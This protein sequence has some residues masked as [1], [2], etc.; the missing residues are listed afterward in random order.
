M[1]DVTPR[2]VITNGYIKQML[3]QN[4]V[5]MILATYQKH[6][7]RLRQFFTLENPHVSLHQTKK[8]LTEALED[9]GNTIAINDQQAHAQCSSHNVCLLTLIYSNSPLH[10]TSPPFILLTTRLSVDKTDGISSCSCA[11]NSSLIS[12][13][14][15]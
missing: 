12:S 10:V 6:R 13:R 15:K 11:L 5:E 8:Q 2:R 14:N 1:G 4:L 9:L 3:K 7:F